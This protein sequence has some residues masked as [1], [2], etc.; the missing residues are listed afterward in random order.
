MG[1]GKANQPRSSHRDFH[2]DYI[3]WT[4]D[5][6]WCPPTG[7]E[8][9]VT[10]AQRALIVVQ[11][12]RQAY[13]QGKVLVVSHKATIRIAICGLLGIDVGRYRYRRLGCPVASVRH[14]GNSV[15][16]GSSGQGVGRR[17][18]HLDERLRTLAREHEV[19]FRDTLARR[20][21]LELVSPNAKKAGKRGLRQKPSL[22]RRANDDISRRGIN[23][24][25]RNLHTF[26]EPLYQLTPASRCAL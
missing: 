5:P 21:T 1:N 8:A 9:A 11:E 7:G 25:F 17:R 24:P 18:S 4:A 12:I 3:R 2:D 6:A 10:I 15:H 14:C 16:M 13:P 20:V 22:A 19:G 26:C 23:R